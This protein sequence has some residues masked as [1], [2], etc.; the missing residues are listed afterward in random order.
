MNKLADD[1]TAVM[2][3][4]PDAAFADDEGAAAAVAGDEGAAA[5]SRS[6]SRKVSRFSYNLLTPR[7]KSTE[8]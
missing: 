5:V 3:E 8:E 4:M 1:W 6:R 2:G 7:P